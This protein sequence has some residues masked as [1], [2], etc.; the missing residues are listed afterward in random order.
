[1]IV[2]YSP[3]WPREFASIADALRQSLEGLAL[4]IDHIGST[5]VPGLAAKDRIDIQVTVSDPGA[6]GP[7]R[8]KLEALGYLEISGVTADHVPAC[9]PCVQSEWEKRFFRGPEGQRPTNLH[10]RISG[11]ANQRYALLFRD[12]LR[13]HPEV[14]AAYAVLKQQIANYHGNDIDAYCEIK[15]PVCDIIM[16]NGFDWAEKSGWVQAA[17]DS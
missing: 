10:V 4:R 11:R 17:S 6:F 13:E 3:S 16:I 14:A 8:T 9:G 7:V 1:M 12:Y 5:A 2:P 15:D